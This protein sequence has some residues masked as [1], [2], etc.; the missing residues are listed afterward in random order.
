MFDRDRHERELETELR[1]YLNL[2]ID[3]KIEAGL[4][5]DE[6]RR[7][8]FLEMGDLERVKEAVRAVRR[9][10]FAEPLWYDLRGGV[11]ALRRSPVFTLVVVLTLAIGIGSSA[12]MLT[13]V[14]GVLLRQLDLPD[15]S[16]VMAVS[17]WNGDRGLRRPSATAASLT[18]WRRG[19]A[20]LSPIAAYLPH[21]VD[22]TGADEPR[23]VLANDLS[24]DFM[25]VI[26]ARAVAGRVFSDDE[27][28]GDG[29]PVMMLDE[30][31]WRTAFGADPGV[32]QRTLTVNGTPR[33]VIGIMRPGWPRGGDVY[34]PMPDAYV[35][36]ADP[37]RRLLVIGRLRD[38]VSLE[39]A[40]EELEDLAGRVH[41][42][43][44]RPADNWA[45]DVAPVLETLVGGVRRTMW[46]L[47]AAVGCVL[48][49]VCANVAS[50]LLA[51]HAARA[52][53]FAVRL[54]LGAS[55]ARLTR[56]LFLE[57]L[58]LTTTGGALGVL[59]AHWGVTFL[60]SAGPA[61]VPRL[62][63]IGVDLNMLAVSMGLTT[64]AALLVALAPAWRA[65]IWGMQ[66][67]LRPSG[68]VTAHGQVTR[69][70]LVMAEL[71]FATVLL[72]GAVLFT[73]SLIK[74]M[75]IPLGF[76]PSGVLALDIDVPSGRYNQ[77]ELARFVEGVEGRLRAL[78]SIAAVGTARAIP[79]ESFG[80][81]RQFRIEGRAAEPGG[82]DPVAFFTPATP[83][84]L[85]SMHATLL[86]GRYLEDT[87]NRANAPR[88]VVINETMA[89][90][91]WRDEDPL[92]QRLR[93][94]DGAV[95]E[96]VGIVSDLRQ[97]Q[98]Q[99]PIVPAMWVAWSQAPEPSMLIVIRPTGADASAVVA[100]AK[101]AVWAV[102]PLLPV[103]PRTMRAMYSDTVDSARFTTWLLAG[104]SVIALGL[105]ALGVYGLVSY[106]VVLRRREIG[107]RLALG[108]TR[109]DVERR[110]VLHGLRLAGIGLATGLISA[111][112]LTR[113]IDQVL[114]GVPARDGVSMVVSIGVLG[115]TVLLASW[116]PARRAARML[117][118]EAM[119][120]TD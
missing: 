66:R 21:N 6:A 79:F 85:P 103:E 43:D 4:S 53:E 114:Y 55:R 42:T 63:E 3:E 71:A 108:A 12:A 40:R 31:Y 50:L 111:L 96:V 35:E 23:E 105:A 44:P 106:S 60:R 25:G 13:V 61:S 22:I 70:V 15:P 73:R 57:G 86:G 101:R 89:R 117:P 27:F 41:A 1:G 32:V 88:V 112:V 77:S 30:R 92:G 51:R 38:D 87:D 80:R 100:D 102:D 65:S 45:V 109:S 24:R 58:L 104:F 91:Y 119:R 94:S 95:V 99:E 62:A 93:M 28:A 34:L 16:S 113:L 2:L 19:V 56:Q 18:A 36:H 107:L 48:L 33:T 98:L 54:A 10:A 14:D 67:A 69:S 5:P 29:P 52:P 68:P 82:R 39:T 26:R 81:S 8:A 47:L 76:D 7:Q 97:Q 59:V 64:V 20:S 74:Q 75:N 11:R 118:T 78:P 120:L 49:I 72:V 116:L 115:A 84:Y 90:R 110:F 17:E 37:G 83:G 46:V 9:G